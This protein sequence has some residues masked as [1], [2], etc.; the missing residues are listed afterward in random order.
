[1]AATLV[2]LAVFLIPHSL[3]GSQIDWSKAGGPAS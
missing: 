2:T 1:M 3:F